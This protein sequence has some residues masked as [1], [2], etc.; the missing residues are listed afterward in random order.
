MTVQPFSSATST[1]GQGYGAQGS[2]LCTPSGEKVFCLVD[3]D[4]HQCTAG[5]EPCCVNGWKPVLYTESS[6]SSDVV[7]NCGPGEIGVQTEEQRD[8]GQAEPLVQVILDDMDSSVTTEMANAH[9]GS[10]QP[11]MADAYGGQFHHDW[12]RNKGFAMLSFTF[13]PPRTGCYR[14]EEYHPGS[15]PNCARYL[16]R[17]ARLEVETGINSSTM[18]QINQ[19]ERGA[20][21]NEVGLL[22]F[23]ADI[24]GKLTM[25]SSIN[26][27]CAEACFWVVD[28]FRLTW[29]AAQCPEDPDDQ[30]TLPAQVQEDVS[31][32]Q[33]TPSGGSP[34]EDDLTD[35]PLQEQES[36]LTLR[37]RFDDDAEGDL[38]LAL[39]E[40]QGTLQ[41]ALRVHFG[42]LSLR[43]TA[44]SRI[45]RRR[46][47]HTLMGSGQNFAIRFSSTGVA[48]NPRSGGHQLAHALQAALTG[49]G[50]SVVVESAVV[51]WDV[52]SSAGDSADAHESTEWHAT[53]FIISAGTAMALVIASGWAWC[54]RMRTKRAEVVGGMATEK[55][56]TGDEENQAATSDNAAGSTGKKTEDVEVASNSTQPPSQVASDGN[57]S[58]EGVEGKLD[59]AVAPAPP[60]ACGAEEH[61]L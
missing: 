49:A 55:A 12:A 41:Q 44:V 51:D 31:M 50:A 10:Y 53:V 7:V 29:V 8:A 11:C 2:P 45:D 19:A 22:G 5:K 23:D 3:H 9:R 40:H 52:R 4:L 60:V 61:N 42:I 38:E 47:L 39:I 30:D 46:R 24:P 13:D 48:S 33:G 32:S 56:P 20:Q 34:A 36:V 26:E 16:P 17:N 59:A 54:R 35:D 15:D 43:V 27:Q 57:S 18:Y 28:A 6:S 14:I 25:R 58:D 37:A 1:Y 21:W